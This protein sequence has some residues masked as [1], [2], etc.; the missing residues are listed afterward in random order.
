MN[1]N[2]DAENNRTRI[3]AFLTRQEVDFIDKLAKDAHFSTGH[4]LTR[5][6][7]IRALV[8]TVMDYKIN[9]EG[10][11]SKEELESKLMKLMGKVLPETINELKTNRKKNDSC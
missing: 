10:V 3:V 7:I 4:K 8:D 6:D 9:A 5:T 1:N 11:H 2:N